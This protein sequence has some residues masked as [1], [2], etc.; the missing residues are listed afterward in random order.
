MT[1][2]LATAPR[3]H[4]RLAAAALGARLGLM[5][6]AGWT[7]IGGRMS[8]NAI[9]PVLSLGGCPPP[10]ACVTISGKVRA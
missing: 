8:I 7:E 6:A 2:K 10:V 1:V 9:G 4:L 3:E 5:L